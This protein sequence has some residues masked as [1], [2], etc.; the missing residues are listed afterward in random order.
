MKNKKRI[1]ISNY[2]DVKNPYYAG[3]G[4]LAINKL[5]KYLSEKYEVIVVTGK[6][7]NSKNEVVDGIIYKR[8]GLSIFGG[9]IGHLFY[10][11]ALPFE[12]LKEKCDL[13]IDSFTPPFSISLIPLIKGNKNVIG[14]V[15]MLSGKDMWRKYKI[16]FDII[17]RL[18]IKLYK[19]FIV[20]TEFSK[21]EILKVNPHAEIFIIPNGTEI[22]LKKTEKIK[23]KH[24]I[25]FLG[26]I[27]VNQKGLD[28]L[29][30][31]YKVV[32]EQINWDMVIAGSGANKEVQYLKKL[33]ELNGLKGKVKLTGRVNGSEKDKLLK[34]SAIVV[35]PSRFETFGVTALEA[36]ASK[37]VVC[38]FDIEGFK[39][40]PSQFSLKAKSFNADD[41][42]KIIISI[43]TDIQKMKSITDGGYDFVQKYS[44]HRILPQYQ[45]ILNRIIS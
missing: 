4:A 37:S 3:G 36:L 11:F 26:R 18:G 10:L 38:T 14:L 2:D 25:L 21:R 8:I 6:Y 32:A 45:K 33:I 27:E 35:I 31:S 12:G 42:A 30:L 16:P 5:A 34:E 22:N 39:W 9:K 28:L 41:L 43:S 40:L 19:Y 24:Q 7:P 20:L 17:E 15:H 23:K 44:W 1:I 29:L 13:W